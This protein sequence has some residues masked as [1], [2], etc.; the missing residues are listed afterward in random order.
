MYLIIGLIITSKKTKN[1]WFIYVFQAFRSIGYKTLPLEGAP[2]NAKK[3][4]IPNRAGKVSEEPGT[5]YSQNF[6]DKRD[7]KLPEKYSWGVSESY[8]VLILFVNKSM[9]NNPVTPQM[10]FVASFW[11]QASKSH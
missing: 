6:V 3:A 10:R 1:I 9:P 5:S 2:Y 8:T 11:K 7:W 4:V